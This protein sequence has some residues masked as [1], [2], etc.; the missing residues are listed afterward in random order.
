[1]KST[2]PAPCLTAIAAATWLC[3]G[4]VSFPV[5]SETFTT[6]YSTDVRAAWDLPE[7]S[8]EPEPAVTPADAQDGSVAIGLAGVVTSVQPQVLHHEKVSLEKCKR[9]AFGIFPGEA[10]SIY[11]PRNSLVPLAG[12]THTGGGHYQSNS[13][14]EAAKMMLFGI[15]MLPNSLLCVP[16]FGKYE[17][18][19]HHWMLAQDGKTR[20]LAKF[21]AEDRERIGAWTWQDE[22]AHPQREIASSCSHAGFFGFHKYCT[23]VIGDPEKLEP[24]PVEPKV[25]QTRRRVSGPYTVTLRLPSLGYVETIAVEEGRKEAVFNLAAVANGESSVEG[26]V[27]FAPA[28]EGPEAIRNAEDR[29]LLE[30]AADREWAVSVAMIYKN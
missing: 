19:T 24:T 16:F 5:G 20:L 18:S 26:T 15:L 23:Y 10:E 21:S 11:R 9:L 6:E 28:A 29:A 25:S 4:C 22:K 13:N 12:W 1:M 17:C 8:Y 3:A 30:A 27:R 7:K 14:D 2:L